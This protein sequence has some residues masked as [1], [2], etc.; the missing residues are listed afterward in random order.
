MI[1]L[2]V[3]TTKKK[4]LLDFTDQI[5]QY[6]EGNGFVHIFV[7]H[8]TCA[9]TTADLADAGAEEDYLSALTKIVP[10]LDFIHP[11]NPN[12]M[13]DHI[14]ATL[15]GTSLT[16]P[17]QNGQLILGTWQSVVLVELDGPRDRQV[18]ITFSKVGGVK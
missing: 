8:T 16:V 5:N 17:F 4:E 1:K 15:I 6:L 14:L 3:Q 9:I 13:P 11:H 10:P 2:S 12:H 7:T 18:V